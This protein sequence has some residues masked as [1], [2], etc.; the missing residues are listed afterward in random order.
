MADTFRFPNKGYEVK[1]LR[2]EDV[3]DSINKNIIDKEV[4]LAIVKRCE[5]DAANFIKEGRWAGIP[6][7]GNIRIPPAVQ[8]LMSSEH[9][10]LVKEAEE[11][12]DAKKY[13]LFRHNL[14]NDIGKQIKTE[15]YYKYMVSKFVG[16]NQK[17]FKTIAKQHG[18]LYA[19]FLCYTLTELS[20]EQMYE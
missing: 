7:I 8:Q 20:T 17:F 9:Q 12:L 10:A 6:F 2:K 19:R 15:R 3:L 13:V 16:K 4:A 1:V 5:I 14:A 11:T 18:D